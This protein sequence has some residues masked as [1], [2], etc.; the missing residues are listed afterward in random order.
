MTPVLYLHGFASGPASSKARFLR[1]R[2]E[3]AGAEVQVPDL[4]AGDFEHLTLTG[5]LAVIERTAA[6]RPMS[7]VGSSMGGYLAALYA[8]RH[9]EV[10]RVVLMAPAFDFA[11]RWAEYLGPE[12][13]AEWRRTGTLEVFH[14]GENRTRLLRYGLMEDAARCEPW[15]D[16]SQPALIFHGAHDDVVPAALAT[17]FAGTHPNVRLEILDSGHEL[18]NVLEYL[19][20]KIE[21]FLVTPAAAP[22]SDPV[23]KPSA[24]AGYTALSASRRSSPIAR[25]SVS[26]SCAATP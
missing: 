15:P 13:V 6:G 8:A 16:F 1:E 4:S 21:E 9:R 22:P 17:R 12:K 24:P 23:V 11:R 3:K 14:Y 25:V 2:L 19:G 5:Q 7:L 10:A 26:G 20:E 18:L